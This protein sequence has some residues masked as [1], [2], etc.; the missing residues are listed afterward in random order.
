MEK[1]INE[2]SFIGARFINLLGSGIY[3]ICIPLFLLKNTG[4]VLVTSVFFSVIQL[5]SIFLLPFL[6]VWM[7]NKNL[8]YCLIFSNALSIFLFLLLNI[9]LINYGFNF[10]FLLAI[11]FVEKINSS[12]FN[13]ASSSIVSR[14]ISKDKIAK[15]NGTKSVFDNI[16]YLMA[17]ALGA[18][19]YGNLGFSFAVWLNIFSYIISIVL[20]LILDYIPNSSTSDKESFHIRLKKGFKI[21]AADKQLFVFF[22][23]FMVLNFLVSPTEEVFAPGI[24]KSVYNFDDTLYGW[25]GTAVSA[26]VIVASVVIGMKDKGN[27]I[28]KLSLYMQSGI[29]I[30]TGVFSIIL[31]KYNPDLFYFIYLILCFLSGIFATFV[32]VPLMSNF[33]IMVDKNYQA[34]FFS[35]LSFFSSLMIPIGTLFAGVMSKAL[36]TDIA[37]LLN[38]VIMF[39]IVYMA[40]RKIQ[41]KTKNYDI[42]GEM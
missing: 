16:A 23:L 42:T 29:M 32:N 25:T 28:M 26:G 2:I 27:S 9:S 8:K 38:G 39:V 11:S 19:L 10:Y 36:R 34:R 21:I 20:S 12:M 40:F 14:I 31:L 35:I 13:V 17:P 7:E 6:G 30:F 3:N 33:Q 4:S 41:N 1:K 22:T 18:V 15:L 5:P 37:Y 24:M